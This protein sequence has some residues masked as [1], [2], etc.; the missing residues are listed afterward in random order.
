M[1]LRLVVLCIAISGTII[2]AIE[3][4]DLQDDVADDWD[5]R[6]TGK[7]ILSFRNA[8]VLETLSDK[9]LE[10]LQR[11]E[12]S[13][14]RSKYTEE[15]YDDQDELLIIEE[16]LDERLANIAYTSLTSRMNT[17]YGYFDSG[18]KELDGK[19]RLS[20]EGSQVNDDNC[21][22]YLEQMVELLH[23]L[24]GKLELQRLDGDE[25]YLD[26]DEK[27]IHLAR[28]LE[29]YGRYD[30]GY[31]T[32]KTSSLG[33]F[34][35]C[36]LSKL[37]VNDSR[38]ERVFEET[39]F[40]WAR[41]RIDKHLD[42]ELRE[43]I[44]TP[45]E[46]KQKVLLSGICIPKS[47]HTRSFSK[48]VELFEI[49]VHSQFK[50]PSELYLDSNLELDSIFCLPDEDS[51]FRQL[52]FMGRLFVATVTCWLLVGIFAIFYNK[53][54]KPNLN[55]E[56]VKASNIEE[57]PQTTNFPT[58]VD[59]HKSLSRTFLETI[60]FSASLKDFLEFCNRDTND[61]NAS[62]Q[63]RSLS[64]R[65]QVDFSNLNFIKVLGT[66]YVVCGHAGL[67][68]ISYSNNSLFTSKEYETD[69]MLMV[70]AI[71]VFVVDSFFVISAML[72]THGIVKK[73]DV[74]N[75]QSD[76]NRE[77]DHGTEESQARK[78]SRDVQMTFY[79]NFGAKYV[80]KRYLRLIPMYILVFWFNKTIFTHFAVGGPYADYGINSRTTHGA[81]Q[82]S[83]PWWTP[84][85]FTSA[86]TPM[87]QKCVPQAWSVSCDLFLV[88]II[89]PVS[90]LLAKRPQIA[91]GVIVLLSAWSSSLA[92]NAYTTADRAKMIEITEGHGE[93]ISYALN[94]LSY[95]YT[96]PHYR[97][98][99]SLVG[100]I[101]GYLI[102]VE[103]RER[104]K[105]RQDGVKN[106]ENTHII[107]KVMNCLRHPVV[108]VPITILSIQPY[109]SAYFMVE[110]RRSIPL[111]DRL[112]S[113]EQTNVFYRVL[114]A[115]SNGILFIRMVTDWKDS[116]FMQFASGKLWK[117][118]VKLNYAV[119]LIHIHIIHMSLWSPTHM[120][121]FSMSRAFYDFFACFS[122]SL[123]I[124]AIL[125]VIFENPID[126]LVRKM[127]I[128]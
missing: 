45:F 122:M 17:D 67:A 31:F 125:Y 80:V 65:S 9:M 2:D 83:D 98:T 76:Q 100:V 75:L 120:R 96:S 4:H 50:L 22:R 102:F 113:F 25:R 64:S 1:L 6:F 60:D 49:L 51:E 44:G 87:G 111:E 14:W 85:S 81:C 46:A 32:G 15:L 119:L 11:R 99:V 7:S 74:S 20:F 79:L 89:V 109:V 112:L 61:S 90:V 10:I 86:W 13:A 55:R 24:A 42:V 52:P 101:A 30:S 117:I 33:S 105:L 47:C 104:R 18:S 56:P 54:N 97:I 121:M 5:E 88:L 128:N 3:P 23:E 70:M 58:K 29:S 63:A 48:N 26:L 77:P 40:C 27:H 38:G 94:D 59:T 84:I 127:I 123:P 66:V 110:I 73:L 39:R 57:E 95:L 68:L 116:S 43:R 8:T 82:N 92:W 62:Q 19:N 72:L 37:L 21:T 41:H 16:S 34:E 115:I 28:V 12:P 69:R 107:L 103:A 118:L 71:G 114:W 36:E 91:F 53:Y 108:T 78:E 106:T 126:K 93:S 35:Q 124:A